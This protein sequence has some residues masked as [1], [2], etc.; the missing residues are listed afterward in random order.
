MQR[1][2]WLGAAIAAVCAVHAGCGADTSHVDPA[3]TASA[4]LTYTNFGKKFVDDYCASC[5]A[6]S[7]QGADRQGAPATVTFDS[8]AQIKA[9]SREVENDVVVLKVMPFGQF[10]KRPSD[11][12]RE[13][14][15]Q[16]LN[17]G[18]P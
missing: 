10:A 12:Q 16:W 8:L 7:V 18:A 13:Q 5:H 6:G 2:A 11:A 3:C 15:G 9:K 4:A 17:C 14:F 1:L